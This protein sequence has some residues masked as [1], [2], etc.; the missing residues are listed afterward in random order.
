MSTNSSAMRSIQ[1]S[2]MSTCRSL[3]DFLLPVR[4]P[5]CDAEDFEVTFG[6]LYCPQCEEKLCPEPLNRC[7]RCAAEIGPYAKSD[8]GCV[9]CRQRI[10]RFDSV[11]CLG[12]YDESLRKAMLSAKWSFSAVRMK[13]LG[14]LLATHRLAELK[15][16]EIDLI[17]SIPHSWRQRLVR[18]FNPAWIV[19]AEVSAT[20]KRPC[21]AN[22][23]FRTRTTRLQKRVSVSERFENQSKSIGLRWPDRA[24]GKRILVVDDVLTT[25]ATIS[26]AA[27]VLK[28]AGAASVHAAIV[29]RVLDPSA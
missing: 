19:A 7:G 28:A 21:D 18:H 3:I 12:M 14:R 16:T 24:S 1:T 23:L 27:R 13:S 6:S 17:V 15:A 11:T 9:H 5:L 26:E 4:C 2:I 10:L 25:G 20:L 8:D 22:F 29:A